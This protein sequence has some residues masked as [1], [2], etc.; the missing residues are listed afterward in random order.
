MH[1][2]LVDEKNNISFINTTNLTKFI[3]STV[4]TFFTHKKLFD[5]FYIIEDACLDGVEHIWKG[6]K[7]YGKIIVVKFD[8][9][10][11]KYLTIGE[12]DYNV[13]KQKTSGNTLYS[14]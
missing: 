5:E 9:I 11:Q 6:N 14:E 8:P 7:Y 4:G 2:F 12:T 1:V 13:F 3:E 10:K